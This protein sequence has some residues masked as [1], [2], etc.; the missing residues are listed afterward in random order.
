MALHSK[1]MSS[2]VQAAIRLEQKHAVTIHDFYFKCGDIVLICNT[3]IE[4][5]LNCKMRAWYLGPLVVLACSKG[6]FDCPVTVFYVIPYLACKSL[7]LPDL[8]KFIDILS[9]C[10]RSMEESTMSGPDKKDAEDMADNH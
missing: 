5:V 6:V 4:K 8:D 10:L 2:Q 7:L 9:D 1:V 3:A